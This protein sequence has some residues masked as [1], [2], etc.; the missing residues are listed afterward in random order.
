NYRVTESAAWGERY[1]RKGGYGDLDTEQESLTVATHLEFESFTWRG[2]EQQWNAGFSMERALADYKHYGT[3]NSGWEAAPDVQCNPGDAYCLPQE[4]YA[5]SRVVY[6]ADTAEAEISFTD[7]YVED[8]ISWGRI[9][10][11]GGLHLGY[12]DYTR[13]DDYAARSTLAYDLYG[14]GVSVLNLGMNR[15]YGKTLLTHALEEEKSFSSRW[16]RTIN[17]DGSLHAWE[18]AERKVFV[19]TRVSELETPYT[20]E[21]SIG[22]EQEIPRGLITISYINRNG[23][24]QLARHV[25]DK[26][27]NGYIYSEWNNNGQSEHEEVT[28]S[29]EQRCGAQS[30]LFNLTWQDSETS[31]ESYSDV[32][33]L[34]DIHELVY[35]N[36][37]LTP[38]VNL[39]RSDYNREWSAN[40][41]YHVTLGYGFAFTNITE[42]RSG[43]TAILDTKENFT[44]EEGE[45]FDIYAD[46]SL[47]SA[48]TFDW[49][50][51]WEY[52]LAAAGTLMLS[53]EV[54]NVFN[55]KLYTGID[56]EYEMGR[57]LWVG[58][59]FTF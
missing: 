51:T 53:A 20:D 19:A 54:Y 8:I 6:P 34:E 14:D 56:A 48:T 12:N 38:G 49:K 52:E 24:D 47:P 37:K 27:E 33:D 41:V 3:T 30:F 36:E 46:V 59:D 29:W 50:L 1:S 11:R 18:K 23:E 58:M 35:Y 40:L 21:W 10:L 17:D 43:Y 45:R 55:R 15:Y 32:M 2:I 4:Q 31:N 57:Q 39:P 5:D 28:L 16:K 7:V 42:Y 25:L 26:D 13:N 22:L 44:S 9:S